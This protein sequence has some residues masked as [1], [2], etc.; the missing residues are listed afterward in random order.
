MKR[1]SDGR[2]TKSIKDDRTGKRVYF[3]ADSE[4]ELFKKILD[5]TAKAERGRTFA[6][7]ANDWWSDKLEKITNGTK[8][9]YS[10]AYKR[11]VAEFGKDPIKDIRPRDIE[12]YLRKLVKMDYTTKSIKNDK[13]VIN[14]VFD[15]AVMDG[16]IQ[17]NPCS[18]VS[19]PKGRAST[20]RNAATSRDE[21]VIKK[22]RDLWLFPYL[23]LMTGMRKGECLALQWQDVDF[24]RNLI[25]VNKSAEHIG[26]KAHIKDT[27]TERGHRSIVL[28]PELRDTLL[29]HPRTRRTDYIISEDGGKTPLSAKQYNRLLRAYKAETGI[30]CTAHQLRHSFAT[31][32]FEAGIPDKVIQHMIGHANISTTKDIYTDVRQGMLE[33]AG[34]Q[35]NEY[36]IKKGVN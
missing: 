13:L 14:L 10:S 9:G 8:R 7:V 4:R 35:L 24:E 31:L 33:K 32:C 34:D 6:E 2:Y 5:Y 27:K 23:A 19:V 18:S 21:D 11:A 30:E 29:Q 1:R 26:S 16:D 20:P 12:A 17:Y 28:L 15:M 22:H 3:Y 36:M 25:T